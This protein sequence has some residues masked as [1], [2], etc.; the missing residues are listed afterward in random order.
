MR[1][2][3]SPPHWGLMGWDAL[4]NGTTQPC[5]KL[6][7]APFLP[8]LGLFFL[9]PHSTGSWEP[10]NHA[11]I[12]PAVTLVA[13][14]TWKS[15]LAPLMLHSWWL[16]P[17]AGCCPCCHPCSGL[18]QCSMLSPVMSWH[19]KTP[20]IP[21]VVMP[22]T[23]LKGQHPV[24]GHQR[25]PQKGRRRHR[26]VGGDTKHTDL[27]PPGTWGW[28]IRSQTTFPCL[29]AGWD[30]R[31]SSNITTC[32]AQTNQ[33]LQ[34]IETQ[35]GPKASPSLVAAVPL[36]PRRPLPWGRCR[37]RDSHPKPSGRGEEG[38]ERLRAGR[39][40]SPNCLLNYSETALTYK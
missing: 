37:V 1:F 40:P 22:C 16:P 39:R 9:W 35:S 4:Q 26:G 29:A 5:P 27:L 24:R 20:Q 28:H 34:H 13:S 10:H 31:S 12:R 23:M 32:T 14:L 18:A 15:P 17:L 2:S 6:P 38:R 8:T 11:K 19:P 7:P 36:S 33:I 21:L 3:H 30:S 25:N